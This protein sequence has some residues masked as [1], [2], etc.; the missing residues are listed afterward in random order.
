MSDGLRGK[1]KNTFCEWWLFTKKAHQSQGVGV[2]GWSKVTAMFLFLSKFMHVWQCC[3]LLLIY[4]RTGS[5]L[6]EEVSFRLMDWFFYFTWSHAP[7]E[8]HSQ[9]LH[10]NLT[11]TLNITFLFA[12]HVRFWDPSSTIKC[13]NLMTG[14]WN[15]SSL[16]VLCCCSL[17]EPAGWAISRQFS[18]LCWLLLDVTGGLFLSQWFLS[19]LLV[20]FVIKY[21]RLCKV[22]TLWL[23]SVKPRF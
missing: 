18:S 20:G 17:M 12:L 14:W 19:L 11:D 8:V 10:V 16:F 9:D 21:A 13:V 6:W 22:Y 15:V 4:Y 5:C 7:P 3:L 1:K 23:D 2:G